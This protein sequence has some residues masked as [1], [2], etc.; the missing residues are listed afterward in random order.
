M[1]GTT[2]PNSIELTQLAI[3]HLL[4]TSKWSK[5]LSIV[6][7]VATGLLIVLA[8]VMLFIVGASDFNFSFYEGGLL[9]LVYLFSGAIYG[10]SCYLLYQFSKNI[11]EAISNKD[12]KQLEL[13]LK[14]QSDLYT[15]YGVLTIILL[16]IYA[17]TIV[18]GIMGLLLI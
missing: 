13:A 10:Y 1:E 16:A 14:N 8:L 2:K 11:K 12:N 9:S 7:F 18:F 6:G 4:R 15:F 5:F 3:N 17:I